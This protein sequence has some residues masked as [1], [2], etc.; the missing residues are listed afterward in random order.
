MSDLI[1]KLK[2][3]Q[4]MSRKNKTFDELPDMATSTGKDSISN[5]NLK[6]FTDSMLE[7]IKE[8]FK[9]HGAKV[10]EMKVVGVGIHVIMVNPDDPKREEMAIREIVAWHRDCGNPDRFLNNNTSD[11]ECSCEEEEAINKLRELLSQNPEEQPY[12]AGKYDG[13]MYG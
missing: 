1:D 2:K 4:T 8:E 3:M 5:F 13:Y 10:P 7:G 12:K 9:A 6:E 11:K